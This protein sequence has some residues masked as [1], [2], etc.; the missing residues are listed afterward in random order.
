MLQ[1]LCRQQPHPQQQQ[2]PQQPCHPQQQRQQ[3]K[4]LGMQQ[5]KRL[6]AAAAGAGAEGGG[7]AGAG[8]STGARAGAGVE[9]EAEVG[10]GAAGGGLPPMLVMLPLWGSSLRMTAM[11]RLIPCQH[12][13]LRPMQ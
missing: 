3:Q 6:A 1:T 5:L 11:S 8:A 4:T 2:H 13:V 7:V 9:E 10:A 12:L